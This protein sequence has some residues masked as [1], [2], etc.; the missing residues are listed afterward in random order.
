M[1]A[2]YDAA[3]LIKGQYPDVAAE[4]EATLDFA[5]RTTLPSDRARDIGFELLQITLEHAL[6]PVYQTSGAIRAK[7]Q[8]SN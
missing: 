3:A 8:N 1:S 7:Y 5:C 4:V 2:L 6:P